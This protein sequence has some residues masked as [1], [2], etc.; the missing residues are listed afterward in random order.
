MT[1]NNPVLALSSRE[2]ADLFNMTADKMLLPAVLVEK[3]FWVCWTLEQLFAFPNARDHFIFKGGTSLSKGWKAIERFSEDIDI[4]FDR[5]WLGFSGDKSPQNAPSKTKRKEILRMALPKACAAKIGDEIMPF[6]VKA[7]R[8]QLGETGWILKLDPADKNNETIL[9]SYPT[10][11]GN[12]LGNDY[13]LRVVKIECGTSTEGWPVEMRQVVPYVAEQFPKAAASVPL[14]I[15]M[16]SIERT[17][18]EKATILHAEAHR[19]EETHVLVRYSRHYADVVA[20]SQLDVGRK[21]LLRDD[22]LARVVAHKMIFFDSGWYEMEKAVRGTFRLLPSA[23]HLKEL[24]ADYRAMRPMY[25]KAPPPWSEIVETLRAL[26][27]EI[28]KSTATSK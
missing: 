26:E 21:S 23:K 24:E 20:L 1:Q 7:C 5:D 8:E 10:T 13:V 15:P 22:I 14:T 18:W 28:N 17:F 4:S 27:T 2:R 19:L 9:F 3:D 16:L 12:S 6:L 25:F 11:T